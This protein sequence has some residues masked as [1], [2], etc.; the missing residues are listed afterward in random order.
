MEEAQ[1]QFTRST[2]SPTCSIIGGNGVGK[3]TL[4]NLILLLT[5]IPGI[6]YGKK[7]RHT[8]DTE[9]HNFL[10]Q[11]LQEELL[12]NDVNDSIDIE[13]ITMKEKLKI[14]FD[15]VESH[16]KKYPKVGD[17]IEKIH[18]PRIIQSLLV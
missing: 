3:S 7:E 18:C 17:Q 6:E 14:V 8:F 11:Y 1:A 12:K 10:L 15:D 13:E 2:T 9:A 5:Q 4:I 16:D